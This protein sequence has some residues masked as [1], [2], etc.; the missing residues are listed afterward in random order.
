MTTVDP[1]QSFA[2]QDNNRDGWIVTWANMKNGDI[3]SPPSDVIGFADHT[4]Q[5]EG[6][7]GV[8]GNCAILGS[9]DLVNY[10]ILH[11]PWG[12]SLNVTTASINQVTEACA[13]LIP[14]ITAGDGNTSITVTALFRRT[15]P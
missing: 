5:V 14:Q 13:S 8:G 4:V 11:D 1:S 9:N 6:T 2:S 12:V 3:G 7:F 10:R 15:K